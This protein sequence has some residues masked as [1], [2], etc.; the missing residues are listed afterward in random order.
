[1][2]RFS[3]ESLSKNSSLVEFQSILYPRLRPGE[4]VVN[5][6]PQQ[7][8]A[9]RVKKIKYSIPIRRYVDFRPLSISRDD[10]FRRKAVIG[11]PDR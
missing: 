9:T 6:G 3:S 2:G 7:A 5:A 11:S 8:E 1:M 10:R 4:G